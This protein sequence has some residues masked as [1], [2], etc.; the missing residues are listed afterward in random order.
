MLS[1][2]SLLFK[3]ECFLFAIAR[4]LIMSGCFGCPLPSPQRTLHRLTSD[5]G[6]Q[7]HVVCELIQLMVKRESY[8]IAERLRRSSRIMSDRELE[9]EK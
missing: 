7:L 5:D 3:F 6:A 8:S 1:E 2:I 4:R 9:A